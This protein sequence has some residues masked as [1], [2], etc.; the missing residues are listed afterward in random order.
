[1]T[2]KRMFVHIISFGIVSSGIF[3]AACA[4]PD[5]RV[6][7]A[8][9]VIAATKAQGHALISS[10]I[11]ELIEACMLSKGFVLDETSPR[12]SDDMATAANPQC[13]RPNT[14]VGRLSIGL[15]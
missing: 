8:C 11:G 15:R 9:K 14:V 10:D 13:Y 6:I 5:N 1:M 2:M 4:P 12:C 3:G 7:A